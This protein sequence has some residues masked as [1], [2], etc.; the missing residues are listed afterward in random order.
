MQARITRFK[1]RPDATEAARDLLNRLKGEIMAQPGIARC[2]AVMNPDG[3]GYVIA[4]IDDEGS[5]ARAS[6][7]SA[8]SGRSSTTIWRRCPSPRLRGAGRLAGL[9]PR[10]TQPPGQPPSRAKTS[11]T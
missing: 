5:C 7:G 11:I 2:I 4:E 1:M 9:T 8:R 3:A 6:T 10:Q